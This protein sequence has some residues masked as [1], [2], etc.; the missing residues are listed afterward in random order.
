MKLNL[1]PWEW[2]MSLAGTAAGFAAFASYGTWQGIAGAAA[3]NIAGHAAH[4]QISREIAQRKSKS[5]T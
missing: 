3:G 4:G 2:I 5:K 1:W